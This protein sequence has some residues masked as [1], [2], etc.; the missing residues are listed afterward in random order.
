M[1]MKIRNAEEADLSAIAPLSCLVNK[2][3]VG[4]Y[5][6]I[7]Q[8]ISVETAQKILVPKL[9]DSRS[10]FRL[11]ESESE[12]LGYYFADIREIDETDLLKASRFIYLAEIM[13]APESQGSGTLMSFRTR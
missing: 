10:I 4:A 12:V 1:I 7:Y 8:K 2:M 5:P 13:I 3:H 11:A 9:K 6:D